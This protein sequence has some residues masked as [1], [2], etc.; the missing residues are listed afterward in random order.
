MARANTDRDVVAA[1]NG[2][3]WSRNAK[4]RVQW[5]PLLAAVLMII[6]HW[7]IETQYVSYTLAGPV[8]HQPLWLDIIFRVTVVATLALALFCLPRWQSIIAFFGLGFL[9]CSLGGR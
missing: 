6:L 5:L 8:A 7:I 4:R 3:V 9:I 2:F 1:K